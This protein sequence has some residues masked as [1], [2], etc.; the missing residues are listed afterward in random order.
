MKS[1]YKL[2]IFTIFSIIL[3]CTTFTLKVLQN[4]TFYTIEIGELILDNGIDM[5]DHFSIHSN[6]AYTYP[7]WLYDV[8][9]YLIFNF[10]RKTTRIN[11]NCYLSIKI[12]EICTVSAF[13]ATITAYRKQASTGT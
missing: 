8:F 7:H 9:I 13:V 6:L 10:I 4:D 12:V 2:R 1:K 3:L 11:L 5:L